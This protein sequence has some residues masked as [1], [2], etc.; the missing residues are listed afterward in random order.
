MRESGGVYPADGPHF[1]IVVRTEWSAT[2]EKR[3]KSNTRSLFRTTS[4]AR[5]PIPGPADLAPSQ[6]AP[7]QS[8]ATL[9]GT[10]S[11]WEWTHAAK[12]A[13]RGRDPTQGQ[14]RASGNSGNFLYA[15]C[16]ATLVQVPRVADRWCCGDCFATF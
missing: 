1:L 16:T 13:P 9:H 10:N 15:S 8:R 14:S 2:T 3:E 5:Q 11:S 7:I 4:L 12:C 6:L